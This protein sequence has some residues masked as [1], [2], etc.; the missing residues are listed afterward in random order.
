MVTFGLKAQYTKGQWGFGGDFSFVNSRNSQSR[1]TTDF[2]DNYSNGFN[3]SLLGGK[4]IS[5]K[6]YL[7][8][9]VD[10]GYTSFIRNLITDNFPNK[11]EQEIFSSNFTLQAGVG[12]RWY[13]AVNEK[14]IVGLFVQ[15]QIRAGNTWI[16]QRNFAARNDT[17]SQDIKVNYPIRIFSA[18][19]NPGVYVNITSQ[20]QLT[21]SIGNLYFIQTIIPESADVNLPKQNSSF[22]L[23]VNIFDFRLGVLYTP[24]RN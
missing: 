12:L 23:D 1:S 4:F 10:V 13:F 6:N 18:N 20:W 16:N 14:N 21:A 15:G 24:K 3:V 22:G 11:I 17:V 2:N 7:Y 19:I 5:T 8:G 9:T